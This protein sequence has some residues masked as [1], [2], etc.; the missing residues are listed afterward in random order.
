VDPIIELADKLGKAIADS[1]PA[2]KLREARKLLDQHPEVKQLL[3]DYQNH[4]DK[5]SQLEQENKP[6][7][8]DDKHKLQELQGKL[9]ADDTFKK[10]TAAQVD[11][12]DL[13]RRVNTTLR[14]HLANTEG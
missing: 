4:A 3:T 1:A 11:Y 12:V 5:L 8:V 2:A 14:K 10:L 13:M 9:I 6:V 7:E